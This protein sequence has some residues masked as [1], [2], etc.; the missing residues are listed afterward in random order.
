MAKEIATCPW[1]LQTIQYK[2]EWKEVGIL[3]N[4]VIIY[5][6]CKLY[7]PIGPYKH[8]VQASEGS[9]QMKRPEA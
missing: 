4:A 7:K 1:V 2:S 3:I 5:D 6:L 8:I 9:P